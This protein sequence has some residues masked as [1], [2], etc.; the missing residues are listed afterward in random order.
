D[1]KIISAPVITQ[2]IING[3]SSINGKYSADEASNL[4]YLLQK[5]ALITSLEIVEQNT[6]GPILGEYFINQS[7]KATYYTF[8]FI[9][10]FML[11]IYQ[12]LGVIV[13]IS[14]VLTMLLIY[15][16]I[17]LFNITLTLSGII[18]IL[19]TIGMAVDAN[20]LINERIRELKYINTNDVYRAI[21]KASE[22][23]F[24]ANL[25]SLIIGAI[26]YLCGSG[27]MKAFAVMLC[28]GI[29][30]SVFIAILISHTLLISYIRYF[31]S[32][33]RF[34]IR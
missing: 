24:D 14:L 27:V 5:G 3:Q 18:G 22:A 12:G 26:M 25:T 1:N 8:G 32:Y 34:L 20:V 13:I 2:E 15:C 31:R 29:L 28:L 21:S 6:I 4:A 23:I 11:I 19:F 10:L 17:S 16:C 33:C 7:Y 9:V 30:C